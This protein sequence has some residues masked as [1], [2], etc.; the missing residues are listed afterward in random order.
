M[1]KTTIIMYCVFACLISWSAKFY[2]VSID[3]GYSDGIVPKGLLQLIAQFGPSLAGIIIIFWENGK[4]GIINLV[5]NVTGLNYHYRWFA[6]ALFFELILFHL[7][8]L[9][10]VI[11]GYGNINIQSN[12][13]FISYFE[14]MINTLILSILTGLGEEIGWRG[15]LLPKLQSRYKIITAALILS[16]VNSIWHL[17]NDCI[18]LILKNDFAGF[19]QTYFPD[20]GLRLLITIPVIFVIIYVFNKTNGSLLI[21]ILFHGSANSS[22]EWV[23]KVTGNSDP[24]F[25]LPIFAAIL[26]I[27]AVYFVPAIISQAKNKKLITQIS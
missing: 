21:M 24:G 17:R 26:W 16:F 1:H 8:L 15:Y 25:L 10:C 22:Y 6:F 2:L 18:A 14:F 23:K 9:F 12:L 19:S 3:T 11:S 27:S 4:K 7:V 20:M 13:L 5:K